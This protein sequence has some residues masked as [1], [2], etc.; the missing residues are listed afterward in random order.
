MKRTILVGS[1]TVRFGPACPPLTSGQSK[2][3]DVDLIKIVRFNKG[4]SS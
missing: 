2:K 1:E 3:S 4:N